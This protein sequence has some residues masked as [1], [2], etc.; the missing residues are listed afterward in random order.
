VPHPTI[1]MLVNMGLFRELGDA[2]LLHYSDAFIYTQ[3]MLANALGSSSVPS[4]K[5]PPKKT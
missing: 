1:S 4:Q 5:D 3:V 2:L